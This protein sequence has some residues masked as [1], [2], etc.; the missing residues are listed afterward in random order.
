M[1]CS[2]TFYAIG[3]VELWKV[4]QEIGDLKILIY[5]MQTIPCVRVLPDFKAVIVSSSSFFSTPLILP[6]AVK[7]AVDGQ[8]WI[9][10]DT[11]FWPDKFY[12]HC[13]GLVCHTDERFHT[14]HFTG[15]LAETAA[16][17]ANSAQ[18]IRPM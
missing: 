2:F 15:S 18:K 13:L 3:R 10:F 7:S 17:K 1:I 4:S 11:F 6:G 12:Q 14:Y 16:P 5:T 8:C 9:I